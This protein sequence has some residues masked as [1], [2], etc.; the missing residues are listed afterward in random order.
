MEELIKKI[1]ELTQKVEFLEQQEKKRI[2]KKNFETILKITKYT[3]IIVLLIIVYTK[4]NNTFIKPTKEK[5]D[6]VEEKI[7]SVDGKVDSIGNT[8]K[9]KWESVK[10]WNPLKKD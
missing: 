9:E 2:K 7:S 4:F 5:I 1:D 6:F 10:N 3:I 8:V